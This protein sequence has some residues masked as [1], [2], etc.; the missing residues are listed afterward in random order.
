MVSLPQYDLLSAFE[1][2]MKGLE[3]KAEDIME[4]SESQR[5]RKERQNRD[6][7]KGTEKNAFFFFLEK[8]ERLWIPPSID[9]FLK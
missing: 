8:T 3:R 4:T 1:D 6:A 5:K 2:Y 7:F 9:F